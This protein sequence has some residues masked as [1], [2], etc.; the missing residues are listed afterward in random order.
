MFIIHAHTFALLHFSQVMTGLV[1]VV[2]VRFRLLLYPTL[3]LLVFF[4]YRLHSSSARSSAGETASP[5]LIGLGLILMH[6]GRTA[7]NPWSWGFWTG[8]WSLLVFLWMILLSSLSNFFEWFH[9]PLYSHIRHVSRA[10]KRRRNLGGNNVHLQL[11]T[12]L[13][14]SVLG[15]GSGILGI[16]ADIVVARQSLEVCYRGRLGGH[17]CPFGRPCIPSHGNDFGTNFA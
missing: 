5:I 15:S 11:V 10:R 17:A 8:T 6:R 14:F 12:A 13:S 7:E 1:S 2:L 9:P 4:A 16:L 3:A